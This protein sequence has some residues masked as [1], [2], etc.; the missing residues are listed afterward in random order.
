MTLQALSDLGTLT[1][2]WIP[3]SIGLG[4]GPWDSFLSRH[5]DHVSVR[6]AEP[7]EAWGCP[8]CCLWGSGSGQS[9]L[10]HPPRAFLSPHA[11]AS[12]ETPRT[13]AR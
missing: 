3:R 2:D 4:H 12:G 9:Q 5:P 10:L 13:L 1:S 8:T 7:A 11:Q 6:A